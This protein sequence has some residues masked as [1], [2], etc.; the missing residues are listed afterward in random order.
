MRVIVNGSPREVPDRL[1]VSEL[2]RSLDVQAQRVAVE[3]NRELVPRGRHDSRTLA[4]ED[5]V[6][7][8]T[9]VGG[10]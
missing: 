8:V 4:A 2:L 6:E 10:G 1:T 5:Q 9:L 7:I 3:V